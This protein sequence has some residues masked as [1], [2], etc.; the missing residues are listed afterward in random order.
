[1]GRKLLKVI[2]LSVFWVSSCATAP[3]Y[4]PF[5]IPQEE[6]LGKVKTIA[7]APVGMPTWIK[8]QEDLRKSLEGEITKKLQASGF[9]ILP[10]PKWEE[11]WKKYSEQL[12]G[13]FDP[14]SGKFDEAKYRTA[15]DYTLREVKKIYNPD[16]VLYARVQVVTAE[17]K[18]YRAKWDGV[19]EEATIGE[20]VQAYSG[21]T[22]ALSLAVSIED[23]NGASLYVNR[24][25]IQLLAKIYLSRYV[26]VPD[27]EILTREEKR[28]S[29]I[30]LALKPLLKRR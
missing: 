29:A 9:T 8:G 6:F 7:L 17:V 24:A 4:N 20:F 28:S 13:Y 5:Q 27:S 1:M 19:T 15:R 25:G 30:S 12:G 10:S 23:P 22:K 21:T 3:P 16:A 18:D 2:C 26:E 11:V 14:V